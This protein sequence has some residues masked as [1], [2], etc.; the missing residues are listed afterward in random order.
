MKSLRVH[1]VAAAALV[2]VVACGPAMEGQPCFPSGGPE[3]VPWL[4]HRD[5]GWEIDGLASLD[6]AKRTG[7][8]PSEA[9]ARAERDMRTE[10]WL[11]AAKGF[12]VVARGD[13]TD[14]R[15]VRQTA[16]YHLAVALFRLQYYG[17]ARKLF[18]AIEATPNHPMKDQAHDWT[19]RRSC[20]G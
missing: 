7:A 19:K 15:A 14:D 5:L 2:A 6:G 11:D 10:F 3:E 18:A 12:L 13:T 17:E 8:S 4:S 16:E 9:F 1:A 20:G